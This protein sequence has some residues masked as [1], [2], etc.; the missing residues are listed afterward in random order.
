MKLTLVLAIFLA[1][2]VIAQTYPVNF[3]KKRELVG[4]TPDRTVPTGSN[5]LHNKRDGNTPEIGASDRTVPTGPNPLHHKR[6][7]N[8]PEIGASDRTVPTGSNPLHN[9]RDGMEP[10]E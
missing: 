5:P 2:I 9:K 3:N 7:G 10:A 4:V 1:L 8:T 6:D